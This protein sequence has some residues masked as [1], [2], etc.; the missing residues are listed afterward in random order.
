MLRNKITFFLYPQT[1]TTLGLYQVV[2]VSINFDKISKGRE[3][4]GGR[5]MWITTLPHRRGSE[6]GRRKYPCLDWSLK[7]GPQELVSSSGQFFY[8]FILQSNFTW[9]LKKTV[10]SNIT[11][12]PTISCDLYRSCPHMVTVL[13]L[14]TR[15][16]FVW[17]RQFS[18]RK[19]GTFF[20][21]FYRRFLVYKLRSNQPGRRTVGGE[22]AE[23]Y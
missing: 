1:R 16:H 22:T 9:L 11:Q 19:D 17:M 23:E 21:L 13:P 2:I 10:R 5:L 3:R 12:S 15:V 14:Y 20:I 7:P 4:Y 8:W 6:K 18:C